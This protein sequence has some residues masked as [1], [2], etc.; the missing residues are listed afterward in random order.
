MYHLFLLKKSVSWAQHLP[1][2]E[3]I[4]T[5]RLVL[6]LRIHDKPNYPSIPPTKMDIFFQNAYGGARNCGDHASFMDSV[7]GNIGAPL[8]VGNE[9][10]D[11]IAEGGEG[12]QSMEL[13]HTQMSVSA[14]HDK[15]STPMQPNIMNTDGMERITVEMRSGDEG[16]TWACDDLQV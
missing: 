11:D 1:S 8:W 5:N 16:T 4:L 3:A 10:E 13:V 2:L 14:G 15:Q 12:E 6:N 9:D 7:L